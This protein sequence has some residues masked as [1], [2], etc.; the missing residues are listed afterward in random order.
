ME[1]GVL[2]ST[3]GTRLSDWTTTTTTNPAQ[4]PYPKCLDWIWPLPLVEKAMATHSRTL[5]WKIPWTERPGRLVYGVTK[6]LKRLSNSTSL[7][8]L[9]HCVTLASYLTSLCLHLSIHKRI[10]STCF[11]GCSER[12]WA[13]G[14]KAPR[15]VPAVR[16][17]GIL[18]TA[19]R[20][21]HSANNVAEK[22]PP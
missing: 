19:E 2:Q 15:T 4:S 7:L 21:H 9:R 10:S 1:P 8:P 17:E 20:T 5:A 3:R 13:P 11:P 22:L 6:S 14:E 18:N 12:E 16:C